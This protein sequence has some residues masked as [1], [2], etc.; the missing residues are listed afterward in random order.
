VNSCLYECTIRHERFTPKRYA[1]RHRTFMFYLDL[2]ELDEVAARLRLVGRNR[3]SLYNFRDADH[4]PQGAPT[5]RENLSRYLAANGVDAAGLKIFLLTNLRTA[6]YLF[7]PV[8]FYFCFRP[9]GAPAGCVAE[10][11]NTFGEM[12]P[13]F[14][15]ASDFRDGRYRARRVKYFY[16]SPFIDLDAILEFGLA[17]P[18]ERLD[19][20]VD[21]R[22][23]KGKFFVSSMSG[24]RRGLTDRNLLG[25]TA[26][27]PFVTLKVIALIHWH[28]WRLHALGVPHRRKEE[29]PEL[30]REVAREVARR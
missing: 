3:F 13:Y 20:R 2:D 9:D 6:G 24:A 7:N 1:F 25:L 21:D 16:I 8:S 26:K 4:L 14:L 18:G 28:A 27:V 29:N 11:G 23:A 12:K 22:N 10:V 30:Q 17:A 15:P 5:V 19:L